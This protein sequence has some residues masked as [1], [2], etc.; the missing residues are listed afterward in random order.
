MTLVDTSVWIDYLNG[1]Q[2]RYTDALDAGIVAG[3]V[4][5][6]DLTFLEIL[7]GI[8]ND[9]EYRLTKRTLMTLGT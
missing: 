5:M 1:V 6:G 7:Q 9:S 2:S 3:T 8:R 4:A